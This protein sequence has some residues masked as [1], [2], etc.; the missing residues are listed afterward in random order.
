MNFTIILY[1]Y[2]SP[3]YYKGSCIGFTGIQIITKRLIA[4]QNDG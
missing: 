3:Q 4:S 1:P 2:H